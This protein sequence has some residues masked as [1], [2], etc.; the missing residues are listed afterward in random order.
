MALLAP[1]RY[2]GSARVPLIRLLSPAL[3]AFAAGTTLSCLDDPSLGPAQGPTAQLGL[4]ASV[5]GLRADGDYTV[6]VRITVAGSEEPVDLP[7]EPDAFPLGSE[8]ATV[9]PITI[10]LTA[11][12]DG[13]HLSTILTLTDDVGELAADTL[14]LGVV[15]QGDRITPVDTIRMEPLFELAIAGGGDGTGSGS[16]DVSADRG[17]PA[18]R[19]EIV[20]GQ[21][22]QTGCSARYPLHT[23]ITLRATPT[24]GALLESWTGDCAATIPGDPC[25]LIMEGRRAAGARF[26][27]PAPGDFELVLVGQP[28][29]VVSGAPISPPLTVEIRD[30]QRQL[31]T[32]FSDRVTLSLRGGPA[33]ATLGGTLAVAPEQGVATFSDLTIDRAATGYVLVASTSTLPAVETAPFTVVPGAVSSGSSSIEVLPSALRTCCDTAE[34]VVTARDA[35]GNVIPGAGVTLTATGSLVFVGSPVLPTDANGIAVGGVAARAIGIKTIS[36]TIAGIG[37]ANQAVVEVTAG[38][39]FS[40]LVLRLGEIFNTYPDGSEPAGLTNTA[41]P[42]TDPT[43]APDGS[44]IAYVVTPC[45]QGCPTEIYSMSAD[46]TDTLNLTAGIEGDASSPAWSN[47]GSRIAFTVDTCLGDSCFEVFVMNRDGS[48]PVN[49]TGESGGSFP[50]W[51][52]GG[53][54]IAF[55]RTTCNLACRDD[56]WVMQLGPGET[57]LLT[58]GLSGPSTAPAFSADGA[59]I[60]FISRPC[61]TCQADVFT[62]NAEDGSNAIPRTSGLSGEALSPA[63]SPDGR[64]LVFATACGS[65]FCDDELY[66]MDADGSGLEPLGPGSDPNWR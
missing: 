58:G 22:A 36:A 20:D 42:E 47:D 21:P 50:A 37:I 39:V 3:V 26:G 51:S 9:Q 24:R 28:E 60:A 15:R 45:P 13:C 32:D 55:T 44:R 19:C 41:R 29:T 14:D 65:E 34:V 27:T 66:V 8:D 61:D 17:V 57:T 25:E 59:A 52:P 18:W 54:R 16:V 10:D 33:G 38:L 30:D 35:A 53:G 49:L 1:L 6:E 12:P 5:T 11:C 43:W 4:L 7:I 48:N 63:W 2:L 31:V 62:M 23:E 40:R 64:Q 56:I 46:G